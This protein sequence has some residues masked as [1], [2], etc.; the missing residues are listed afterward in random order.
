M[1]QGKGICMDFKYLF[2]Y[3]LGFMKFPNGDLYEGDWNN[4]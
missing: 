4:D 3:T 2:T 1:M